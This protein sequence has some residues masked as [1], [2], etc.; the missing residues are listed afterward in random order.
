M[1][2]RI[3]IENSLRLILTCIFADPKLF[4]ALLGY[5]GPKETTFQSM[6]LTGI[7]FYK[8][9][10]IREV[11]IKH[12]FKFTGLRRSRTFYTSSA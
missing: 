2:D 10:E 4:Q 8:N 3:I 9:Q 1:E 12:F 6:I 7:L 11:K 5:K